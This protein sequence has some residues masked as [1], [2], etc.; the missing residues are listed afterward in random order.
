MNECKNIQKV[1]KPLT[2]SM[3]DYLEAI[4]ELNQEKSFV[5]VKDIA[6]KLDVKMPTVTS[7]LKNFRDREFVKYEKYEFVELTK[8]GAKIGR[9]MRR[10]HDILLN[11]LTNILNID[12]TIADDEA[13]K[14]EHTLSPETLQRII[15]FMEFIDV[16]PRAGKEWL[17]HFEDFRQSG[18]TPGKCRDQAGSEISC[19]AIQENIS[20]LNKSG[21]K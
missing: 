19:K 9:D 20:K 13:C 8:E 12:Y 7:M 14:M 10:R 16:C 17:S 11:F 3:E 21:S 15:D 2:S 5:R 6:K 4:Y 18:N 1:K